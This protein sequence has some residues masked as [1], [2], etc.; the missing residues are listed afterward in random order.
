MV[1][2][3]FAESASLVLFVAV[4]VF[5]RLINRNRY[6]LDKLYQNHRDEV[7]RLKGQLRKTNS[8]LNDTKKS[9]AAI[10]PIYSRLAR[11]ALIRRQHVEQLPDYILEMEREVDQLKLKV[12]RV[13][14][15]EAELDG[16]KLKITRVGALELELEAAKQ[17]FSKWD[18]LKPQTEELRQNDD[19]GE[20]MAQQARKYEQQAARVQALEAEV[21]Q[22]QSQVRQTPEVV[23]R[24]THEPRQI[25]RP[26]GGSPQAHR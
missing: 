23:N 26:T 11:E 8:D 5:W 13:A 3:D 9:L 12:S 15:M 25:P 4:P 22:L 18:R 16:A 21:K 20:I 1:G 10:D 2:K 17:H 19:R 6:K 24:I 14:A 7:D